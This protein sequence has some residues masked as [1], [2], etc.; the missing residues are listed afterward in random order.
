[1]CVFK[2]VGFAAIEPP[3]THLS[4]YLNSVV[5]RFFKEKFFELDLALLYSVHIL[6]C[7][8]KAALKAR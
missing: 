5:L 8:V 4:A 3:T 6:C 7:S 1:M 2:H